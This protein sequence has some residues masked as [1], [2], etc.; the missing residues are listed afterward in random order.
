M[1]PKTLKIVLAASVALNLF[2]VAAGATL[3]VAHE[4]AEARIEA[5]QRPAR[6]SSTLTLIER[7]SPEE[8]TRV[9]RT[10]K[11][12]ALAAKPDFEEARAKRREAIALSASDQFDPERVRGLLAE[13]RA[14]ELRGRARLEAEAVRLF[15]TLT[16]EDRAI[17]SE[18]LSRK[19]R[20]T[21]RD[22]NREAPAPDAPAR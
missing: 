22:R 7:L 19:G 2:G 6:Q 13:S 8:R 3:W 21:P 16:P 4:R 14:A 18:I 20:T 12:S 9:R 1:S 10:L 17:L 15:G 5:Q 11:A